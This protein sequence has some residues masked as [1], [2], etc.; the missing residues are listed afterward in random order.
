MERLVVFGDVAV[1]WDADYAGDRLMGPFQSTI[2]VC[3]WLQPNTDLLGC[4][5]DRE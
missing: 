1:E 4:K 5:G 3:V 2:D